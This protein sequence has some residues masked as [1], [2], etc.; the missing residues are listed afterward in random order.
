M[1]AQ[2]QA[3][4]R[5]M[6]DHPHDV[7]LLSMREQARRCSV[8]PAT[9][10]RLAKRLGFSG[11]DDIRALYAGALRGAHTGFS[12][13]AG[14]QLS[15]QKQHG[16]KALAVDMLRAAASHIDRLSA[17]D[18]LARIVASAKA[19]A[20]ARRV[21]SLGLRACHPLSWHLHYV[22]T[23]LG[24]R[25]VL[26]DAVG[27]TGADML[28]TATNEDV[29]FAASVAPYTR[30][31]IDL[32]EHAAS[33]GLPI[34]ALTDSDASPLA[35]IAS[36]VI[37]VPIAGPSFFHTMVPAFLVT[38]ILATLI[39]GNKGDRALAALARMDDHLAALDIHYTSRKARKPR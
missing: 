3:A 37:V 25:T 13:N 35:Q 7:A 17:D 20:S 23:L 9:M 4:A 26:L 12:G 16:D 6:L 15:T 36:H 21:Y 39:T 38:E 31:S 2:L 30:A 33:R 22:L 19:L 11:F 27:N 18:C 29:L 14:A 8:Q 10:T 34:V 1:S 28:A 32:A 24:E 5:Y